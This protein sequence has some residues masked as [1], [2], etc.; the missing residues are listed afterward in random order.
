VE[1][2]EHKQKSSHAHDNNSRDQNQ[3]KW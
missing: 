2:Q 1:Q 3:K